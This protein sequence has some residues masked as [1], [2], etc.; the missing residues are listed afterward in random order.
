MALP[1]FWEILGLD[2]SKPLPTVTRAWLKTLRD[3]QHE[4]LVKGNASVYELVRLSGAYTEAKR[5]VV[6]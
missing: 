5:L 2:P 3:E 6:D 1:W 4:R